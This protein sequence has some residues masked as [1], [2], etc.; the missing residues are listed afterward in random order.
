LFLLIYNIGISLLG[1]LVIV[2]VVLVVVCICCPLAVV[3]IIICCVCIFATNKRKLKLTNKTTVD[4]SDATS[5]TEFET[6]YSLLPLTIEEEG[7]SQRN[8]ADSQIESQADKNSP[9]QSEVKADPTDDPI[10]ASL[11]QQQESHDTD[12]TNSVG[13]QQPLISDPA[14]PSDGQQPLGPIAI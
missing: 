2:V 1:L 7:S 10:G 8:Q 6:P 5:A 13:D 3:I 4:K 14:K 11:D 12:S 9:Q